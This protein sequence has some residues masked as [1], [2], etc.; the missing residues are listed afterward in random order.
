MGQNPPRCLPTSLKWLATD[1][2]R[3]P[4]G[5]ISSDEDALNYDRTF[6]HSLNHRV[7]VSGRAGWVGGC[8]GGSKERGSWL[9]REVE[10]NTGRG[11]ELYNAE[12]EHS[13]RWMEMQKDGEKKIL[14]KDDG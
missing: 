9:R 2:R 5:L 11:G 6:L 10:E 1:D 12:K 4:A 7:W 3:A 8:C 14:E 13:K